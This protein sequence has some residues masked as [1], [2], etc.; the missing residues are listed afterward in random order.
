MPREKKVEITLSYQNYCP[1]DVVTADALITQASSNDRPTISAYANVWMENIKKNHEK[2]GPFKSKSVGYFFNKY[3]H[4]PAICVGSGPSLMRNIEDLKKANGIPILSCL[5]N[6]HAMVDN[7]IEVDF[8][9]HLD[10]NDVTFDEISEGGKKDSNYYWEQTKG[11]TLF[12]YI[13]ANSKV[14]EKWQGEVYFFNCPIPDEQFII[15]SE[16]IEVFRLL[17]STGG[18]VLGACVYL[19]KAILGCNP[20][21]FIGADFSFSYN[22]KFHSWDSKY[23]KDIGNCIHVPDIF[24]NKTLTWQSYFNFK[25]W[26][27]WMSLK[28]PGIYYNCTEGGILGSYAHGNIFSIIQMDLCDFLLTYNLHEAEPWVKAVNDP[29]VDYRQVLY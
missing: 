19:A 20:I 6:F 21:A 4:K 16:K 22:K 17:V 13:G 11:K 8:Y 2:H 7:E 10:G 3:K 18:N 9:V 5:H 14:L 27:E 28:I 24:G 29:T 12:S 26:F 1:T 15:D 23:D 25:T